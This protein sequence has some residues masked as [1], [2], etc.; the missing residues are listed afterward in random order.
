[1]KLEPSKGAITGDQVI[2][3]MSIGVISSSASSV[4]FLLC[5]VAIWA[6]I[7]AED[8]AHFV[9]VLLLVALVVPVIDENLPAVT[10]ILSLPMDDSS[11]PATASTMEAVANMFV[12]CTMF[13]NTVF[14]SCA[15]TCV[16]RRSRVLALDDV[17]RGTPIKTLMTVDK[18]TLAVFA[19]TFLGN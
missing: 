16:R 15:T 14:R 12:P 9:L 1:M 11:S 18:S 6:S 19:S 10:R 13:L 2:D 7:V 8:K 5:S 4:F 3:L 17:A